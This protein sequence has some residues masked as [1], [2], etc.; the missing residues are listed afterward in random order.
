M[1]EKK[2]RISDPAAI[3][4]SFRKSFTK[5]R[6]TF[7]LTGRAGGNGDNGKEKTVTEAIAET[8]PVDAEK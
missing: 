6:N 2:R 1:P 3:R 8:G 4:S 7:R 5:V